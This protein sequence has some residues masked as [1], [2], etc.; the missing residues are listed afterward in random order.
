MLPTPFNAKGDLDLA[1]LEG[2]VNLYVGAGVNGLTTL[3][4]TSEVARLDDRERS[5]VVE[6]VVRQA[7]GR[8]PVVVGATSNGLRTTIQYSRAAKEAGAAAV[9]VTRRVWLDRAPRHW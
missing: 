1:G 4:V 3:G 9:M 8:V 7:G 5:V 2:I 6:A